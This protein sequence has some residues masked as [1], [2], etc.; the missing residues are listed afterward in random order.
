MSSSPSSAEAVNNLLDAMRQVVTLGASDLHLKAGS[1]P[2]VRLNGDLVPI[3]GAWTFSA[4]DMDAV[5]REL[6]RHVPNRLRE[7]EQAGEA[8]L[9]Y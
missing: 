5:V 9:A 7:F 2:Y 8:D 3:P 1:P 4:E 6:S